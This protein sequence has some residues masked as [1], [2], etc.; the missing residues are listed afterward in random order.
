MKIYLLRFLFPSLLL[1]FSQTC[2]AIGFTVDSLPVSRVATLFY[3]QVLEKPFVLSPELSSDNRPITL[4]LP[5]SSHLRK[6]FIIALSKMGVSVSTQNGIDYLFLMTEQQ[7]QIPKTVFTY[8]PRYRTVAYLAD[9][10]STFNTTS[11]VSPSFSK[12]G[13]TLVISCASA[14]VSQLKKVLQLIDDR[15]EQVTVTAYVFEVQTSEHNGSGLTLAAKLLSQKF[16]V[17][18]GQSSGQDNFLKIS[19]PDISFLYELFKTDSRFTVVSSPKLR[20]RSGSTANFSVGQEVPVLGSVTTNGNNTSQSVEYRSSGVI[21]D[22]TPAVHQQQIDLKLSQQ[23]SN[24]AKTDTGVNNS[25]TL[26]KRSIT[27]DISLNDGDIILI[28]GLAE[29]RNSDAHAGLNFLPDG[30]FT[31]KSKEKTKSDIVMILQVKKIP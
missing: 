29:S 17:G 13:D 18:F 9:S 27:T 10:L 23:L 12:T 11:G 31:S 5:D 2:L 30:W 4:A 14:D 8:I 20:V 6:D 28:G 21:F 26:T 22:V 7:K 16:T 1:L 25:P 19:T 24:F 3:S 15:A